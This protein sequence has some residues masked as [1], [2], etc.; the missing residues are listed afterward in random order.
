[1]RDEPRTRET[2]FR[3]RPPPVRLTCSFELEQFRQSGKIES[4][5]ARFVEREDV[6]L[7]CRAWVGRA[8]KYAKPIALGILDGIAAWQFQHLP[9][10]EA[11]SSNRASFGHA[12]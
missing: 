9:R 10:R 2:G 12:C 3:R 7:L 4:H 1:M 5:L 8:E 11:A 6:G